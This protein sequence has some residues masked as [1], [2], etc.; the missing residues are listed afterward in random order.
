MKKEW[1]EVILYGMISVMF[2]YVFFFG[3]MYPQP[4]IKSDVCYLERPVVYEGKVYD[5]DLFQQLSEHQKRTIL[6]HM[7]P[8]QIQIRSAILTRKKK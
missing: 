2:A 4:I 5:N 8:N 3:L 1:F 6:M 7:K